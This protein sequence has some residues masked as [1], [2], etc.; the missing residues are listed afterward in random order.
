MNVSVI[1]ILG[2]VILLLILCILILVLHILKF[3]VFISTT[4]CSPQKGIMNPVTQTCIK[5]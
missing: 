4:N 3:Q 1:I 5:A 2:I